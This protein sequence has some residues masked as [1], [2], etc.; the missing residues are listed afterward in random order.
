MEGLSRRGSRV[1]L[2]GVELRWG[3]TGPRRGR[4]IH[5]VFRGDPGFIS[6]VTD[7]PSSKRGNPNLFGYL[8]ACLEAAGVE[9]PA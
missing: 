1:Y 4:E 7:N 5:I 3:K 9:S 8:A 6:S 2:E